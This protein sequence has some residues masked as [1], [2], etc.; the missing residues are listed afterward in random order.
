MGELCE[1]CGN[2]IDGYN[3]ETM[4]LACDQNPQHSNYIKKCHI[5]HYKY[6]CADGC[7]YS[8]DNCSN[9]LLIG[10]ING[11]RFPTI[12]HVCRELFRPNFI[13]NGGTIM[14]IRDDFC[15]CKVCMMKKRYIAYEDKLIS[16]SID[17]LFDK[18]QINE[19][20]F[21]ESHFLLE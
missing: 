20:H 6:I 17:H 9:P 19:D 5:T 15:G 7:I 3:F 18:N 2:N 10:H 1:D 14:D 4:E 11:W 8:C 12:C 16:K 21:K 13:W